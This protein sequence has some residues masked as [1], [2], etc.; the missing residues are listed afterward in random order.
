M[1]LQRDA[2]DKNVTY[3]PFSS[4]LTIT[5]V[6]THTCHGRPGLAG[7]WDSETLLLNGGPRLIHTYTHTHTH[8]T[9][10]RCLA[11]VTGLS[12]TL[13]SLKLIRHT[14]HWALKNPLS[15]TQAP[16]PLSLSVFAAFLSQMLSPLKGS[17]RKNAT[18]LFSWIGNGMLLVFCGQ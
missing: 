10:Q 12:P 18:G 9:T 4:A 3:A 15:Y 14:L 11:A 7:G 13:P 2:G 6:L 1:L 17:V 5:Y 16:S 8:S